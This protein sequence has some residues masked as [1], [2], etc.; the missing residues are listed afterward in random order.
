MRLLLQQQVYINLLIS[1]HRIR[2]TISL[3]V[4]YMKVRTQCT[5]NNTHYQHQHNLR[6]KSKRLYWKTS[7]PIS[8][9]N[10]RWDLDQS[11]NNQ[12]F[13]GHNKRTHET[14]RIKRIEASHTI[15]L[16][17]NLCQQKHPA[18]FCWRAHYLLV[19]SWM[20]VI[21]TDLKLQSHE[22]IH[23]F[24]LVRFSREY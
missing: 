4:H 3:E 11:R 24:F 1:S 17:V 7:L 2:V 15:S 8:W 12:L 22:K 18:W 5:H 19:I 16:Q 13:H 21:T 14:W 20:V 6:F 23:M 9:D 10:V